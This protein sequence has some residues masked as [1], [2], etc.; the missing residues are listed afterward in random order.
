MI[1]VTG[2]NG[3]LGS[4]LSKRLEDFGYDVIRGSREILNVLDRKACKRMFEENDIEYVIHT[5]VCGGRRTRADA[6]ID[7]YQ[8]VV[9]FENLAGHRDKFKM[10]INF[11]SGA[12]FDRSKEIDVAKEEDVLSECPRDYYGLSKNLIA[13]RIH[14]INDNIVNLRIFNCFGESELSDRMIKANCLRHLHN[15]EM[16]VH[17]NKKMDFFY[18]EDLYK[19]VILYLTHFEKNLPTDL[20][21]CY[22]QKFDLFGI[23]DIIK[24]LTGRANDVRLID[25]NYSRSYTGSSARLMSLGIDLCGIESGILRVYK[26]LQG[27]ENEK[28]QS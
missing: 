17:S 25:E 6:G 16:V 10:M 20:N 9:M 13:K 8:N 22:E 1:L 11:G 26:F 21:L 24:S 7:L 15:E 27:L 14:G 18:I 12:A 28:K 23:T 4:F 5:A 2:A 19:V 3:Y